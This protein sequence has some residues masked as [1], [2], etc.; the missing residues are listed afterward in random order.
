MKT[1]LSTCTIHLLPFIAFSAS[2][3]VTG[4]LLEGP[5]GNF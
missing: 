4:A 3:F 1:P 2:P 5:G